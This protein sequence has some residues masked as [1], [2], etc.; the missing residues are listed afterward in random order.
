MGVLFEIYPARV[1]EVDRR[2]RDMQA[3]GYKNILV[4]WIGLG[5]EIT[6]IVPLSH[7]GN[8]PVS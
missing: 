3:S 2:V 5:C 7:S 8:A 4:Q 6:A 1:A